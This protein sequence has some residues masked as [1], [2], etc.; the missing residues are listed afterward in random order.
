MRDFSVQNE[1]IHSDIYPTELS[2]LDEI[3]SLHE[4]SV[5][6]GPGV[7]P[8]F[9]LLLNDPDTVGYKY[10]ID[11]VIAGFIMFRKGFMLSGGHMDLIREYQE[12]TK[13]EL[14]YTGDSVIVRPEYR[15][16]GIGEALQK[17]S[18]RELL[19]R[20]VVF[21]LLEHWVPKGKEEGMAYTLLKYNGE[22][23]DMGLHLNFYKDYHKEGFVC[24]LC[25]E[26][27]ICSAHIFI[28]KL[29]NLEASEI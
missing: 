18:V 16:R 2:D 24:R 29:N 14:T 7:R 10:V 15:R 22:S 28:C 23:N 11:G 3:V 20:G 12:F 5:T 21:L 27:C 25:G 19:R 17:T 4:E 1:I 6:R 13:G 9:E 26:D 8:D